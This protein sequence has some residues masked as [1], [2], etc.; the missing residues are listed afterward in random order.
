[1]K[2]IRLP[3]TKKSGERGPGA[4]KVVAQADTSLTDKI[5]QISA[6]LRAAFKKPNSE[7]RR[8]WYPNEVFDDYVIAE[9]D[10]TAKLFKIP[11]TISGDQVTFGDPVQV[12][13][14]YVEVQPAGTETVTAQSA[15]ERIERI[16]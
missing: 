15:D 12:E 14:E 3:W 11:Y 2:K 16:E 9:E 4:I 8:F 1:M 10:E 5:E 6:A 13:E 7:D